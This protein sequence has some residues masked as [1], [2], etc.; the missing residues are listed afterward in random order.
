MS[1]PWGAACCC[2]LS[3]LLPGQGAQGL[4]QPQRVWRRNRAPCSGSGLVCPRK[5]SRLFGGR[6]R[7]SEAEVLVPPSPR[8]P[9]TNYPA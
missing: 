2:L 6:T 5:L 3:C 7:C 1:S 9:G 4:S 8:S